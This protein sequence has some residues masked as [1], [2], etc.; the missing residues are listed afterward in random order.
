[1][2]EDE[3][4]IV[5][6]EGEEEKDLEMLLKVTRDFRNIREKEKTNQMSVLLLQQQER[7][8]DQLVNNLF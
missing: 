4:A 2:N 8:R 3:E 7:Y 5:D 6:E 1:M